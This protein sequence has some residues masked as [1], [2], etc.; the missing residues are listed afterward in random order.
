VAI[1]HGFTEIAAV[2]IL[3]EDGSLS[4][5]VVRGKNISENF[6]GSHFTN[7]DSYLVLSHFKGHAIG[8]F[9]GAIKNISIGIASS[10]GKTNIHTA[11]VSSIVERLWIDL[12]QQDNFL[13]SMAEAAGTVM[14]YLG[15]RIVY[16]NVMNNLSIDCDCDG[17]PTSPELDDIGILSSLDPGALDKA[18]VDLIYASD[19]QRSASLKERIESRNGLHT[20]NHAE[21]LGLGSL[22]Y[23]LIRL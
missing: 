21:T 18:C 12:A 11:G 2:D 15:E 3:D 5:P 20:L 23:E 22:Q 14:G 13:E 16:I 4:L 1:D 19:T 7:Y 10:S 17:N 6:V 8:G 9:G